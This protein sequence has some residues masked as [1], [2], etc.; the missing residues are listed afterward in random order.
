MRILVTGGNGQLGMCIK[1]SVD[2]YDFGNGNEYYFLGHIQL[3]VADYNNICKCLDDIKPN[4]VINCAAYVKTGK[5]E[6]DE[7]NAYLTNAMGPTY[8]AIACNE[9]NIGLIH[10]STDFVFDGTKTTAYETTDECH[11]IN[12]YG[13]SKYCGE[14]AIKSIYPEAIIIRTSWLYS[15]YGD[16]F[17]TKTLRN[18]DTMANTGNKLRY[19]IDQVGCPTYARNLADFI[20]KDLIVGAKDMK[21]FAQTV[22]HYTDDGIASRYDFAK[23]IEKFIY[24]PCMGL[25]TYSES[26]IEGITSE[27]Y[28]DNIKRPQCCIL[29]KTDLI[30]DFDIKLRDWQDSLC[31]CASHFLADAQLIKN[32]LK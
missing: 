2:K 24:K 3:N 29:S 26:V 30:D 14:E 13:A 22:F 18:I 28:S 20:V 25:E 31:D 5:A 27:V 16:N 6:G 19:L 1:D 9:R 7:L 21:V 10:I 23:A 8:L 11:P 4:I 15:E 17:L 12:T 32:I